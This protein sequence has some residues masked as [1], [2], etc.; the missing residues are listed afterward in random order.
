MQMKLKTQD[1]SDFKYKSQRIMVGIAKVKADNHTAIKQRFLL[2]VVSLTLLKGKAM[3]MSRSTARIRIVKIEA[4]AATWL[5]EYPAC[6]SVRLSG[7]Q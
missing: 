2:Q 7:N 5:T 4:R 3:T 1:I 6:I